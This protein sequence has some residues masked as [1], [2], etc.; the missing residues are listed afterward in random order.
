VIVW[1]TND[2][3]RMRELLQMGVDGLITDLPELGLEALA[4][5]FPGN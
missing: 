3:A 5:V 4:D 2:P 1:G